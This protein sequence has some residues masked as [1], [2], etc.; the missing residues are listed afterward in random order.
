MI[1]DILYY[2]H[3]FDT[4]AQVI[5]SNSKNND[6]TVLVLSRKEIHIPEYL[7]GDYANTLII[8]FRALTTH[9]QQLYNFLINDYRELLGS[10]YLPAFK[11]KNGNNILMK[12]RYQNILGSLI[13]NL[14][15]RTP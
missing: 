12:Q 5:R 1:N 2:T 4:T 15:Y 3:H 9:A 14:G 10:F 6:N 11:F 8:R 7:V 13:D